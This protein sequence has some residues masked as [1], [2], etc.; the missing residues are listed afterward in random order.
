MTTTSAEQRRSRR[1]FLLLAVMF[2]VPPAA[3]YLLYYVFPEWIPHG[4]VNNGQ[5]MTPIH[6]VGDFPVLTGQGSVP[7]NQLF[8]TTWS[9]VIWG[10]ASCDAQCAERV[11]MFN[12]IRELLREN[13]KRLRVF[14]VAPDD[15]TRAALAPALE[16]RN[17]KL[18]VIAPALPA[19]PD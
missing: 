6:A 11:F 14:F 3:A 2:I 10:G 4:K 7:A 13:H 15:A 8:H 19:P 12:N 16:K 17:R 9:L 18:T 1:I 5:L